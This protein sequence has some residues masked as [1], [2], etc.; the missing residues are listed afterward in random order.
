[1]QMHRETQTATDLNT[2]GYRTSRSDTMNAEMT[3]FRCVCM[4]FLTLDWLPQKLTTPP[5]STA[6]PTNTPANLRS[7]ATRSGREIKYH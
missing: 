6:P 2:P 5:N 7:A 4:V 3:D 1:M